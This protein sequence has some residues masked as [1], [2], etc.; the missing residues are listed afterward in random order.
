MAHLWTALTA[1]T[2][3]QLAAIA[4]KSIKE[5]RYHVHHSREWLVRFGD[6]TDESHRR[7]QDALDYLLPYTR[8]FFSADDVEN[9]IAAA[10]IGPKTADLEAAWLED[11]RH[12]LDEATLKLPEPVKHI[13]TGKHG[14]HSEHMGYVLA[15]MQSIARQHPGATW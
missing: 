9:A 6:G 7:A 1:S 12:A 13:T 8:E 15:E 11:V 3:E 14:E 5:T 4:A 2:D 10:G